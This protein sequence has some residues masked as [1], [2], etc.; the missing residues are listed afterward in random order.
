MA[1]INC[2][3]KLVVAEAFAG[4]GKTTTAV[5]FTEARPN[6]RSLYVCFNRANAMEAR[7]RFG[8]HVEC[9][10]T[11]AIAWA[12]VGKKYQDQLVKGSWKARQF[13]EEMGL[14]D[15]RVAAIAQSILNAYFSS[16]DAVFNDSHL[17]DA[18]NQ[19]GASDVEL[20]YA[21]DAA[22]LAWQRMQRPGEPISVPHDAYLK[23]W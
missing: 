7:M 17:L 2:Q 10:S 15:V 21:I 12:A 18:K 22:R 14:G 9:K 8:A 6:T 4:A 19:Y 20:N 16:S 13:Q 5:G 1:V 23:I 11:H 3:D